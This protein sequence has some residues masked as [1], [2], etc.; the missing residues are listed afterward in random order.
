MCLSGFMRFTHE[1]EKTIKLI[2]NRRA[3]KLKN[4]HDWA[5]ASHWSPK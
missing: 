3:D 1:L 5:I 2:E 4:S